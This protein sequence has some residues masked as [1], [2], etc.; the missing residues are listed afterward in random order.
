RRSPQGREAPRKTRAPRPDRARRSTTGCWMSAWFLRFG[1]V[2]YTLRVGAPRRVSESAGSAP[3]HDEG[4]RVR[5]DRS[6]GRCAIP[7]RRAPDDLGEGASEGAD[8]REPYGEADLHD[9]RIR[10]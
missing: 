5:F 9:R 4:A 1:I 3:A 8:A 2:C 6:V 10:G 7:A